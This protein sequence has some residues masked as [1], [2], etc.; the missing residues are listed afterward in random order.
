MSQVEKFT[1]E[2]L[3]KCRGYIDMAEDFK[4]RTL[5]RSS[6]AKKPAVQK[7]ANTTILPVVLFCIGLGGAGFAVYSLLRPQPVPSKRHISSMDE[8]TQQLPVDEKVS[9]YMQEVEAKREMATMVQKIENDQ[10]IKKAGSQPP[11]EVWNQ[12]KDHSYGLQLDQENAA[13]KVYEDINKDKNKNQE[14]LPE[15]RINARLSNAKWLYEMERAEQK[16]F[17]SNFIRMA[18]E[19]GYELTLNEQ[20]VVVKVR[21]IPGNKTI[22]IDKIL[23]QLNRQ[24]SGQ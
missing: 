12:A 17:V 23:D 22:S 7:K 16:Q 11:P 10:M 24:P 2:F 9:R 18:K 20:L 15:D 14:M 21:R 3:N 6:E 19:N 4:I 5:P 8:K 13:E 1:L